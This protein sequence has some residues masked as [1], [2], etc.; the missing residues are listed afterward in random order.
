MC[1]SLLGLPLLNAA[2]DCRCW[3]PLMCLQ[4]LGLPLLAGADLAFPPRSLE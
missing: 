1:L 2:A 4:L 3:L